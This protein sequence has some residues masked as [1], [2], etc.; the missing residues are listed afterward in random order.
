MVSVNFEGL[1]VIFAVAL[2]YGPNAVE[3]YNMVP[4]KK[5]Q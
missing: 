5:V 2:F 4:R 3:K 1:T